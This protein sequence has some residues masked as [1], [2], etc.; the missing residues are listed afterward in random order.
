MPVA[1]NNYYTQ[2]A[3]CAFLL[4]NLHNRSLPA[5]CACAFVLLNLHDSA[6]CHFNNKQKRILIS[7]PFQPVE[8]AA[9]AGGLWPAQMCVEH[10]GCKALVAQQALD[11]PDIGTG[12]QKVGGVG[13][14]QLVNAPDF[15][16]ACLL[17]G[18]RE[19]SLCRAR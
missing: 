9:D 12:L 15:R 6:L 3:R 19:N 4:F 10:G 8:L 1:P 11:V 13:V 18:G 5:R 16:N 14:A 2:L 17:L 7:S